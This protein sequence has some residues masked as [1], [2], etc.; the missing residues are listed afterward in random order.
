MQKLQNA[1]IIAYVYLHRNE[2]LQT[3]SITANSPRK[4]DTETSDSICPVM[5]VCR[6]A[7]CSQST[8]DIINLRF[9]R[10]VVSGSRRV[11]EDRIGMLCTFKAKSN[12]TKPPIFTFRHFLI[13]PLSSNFALRVILHCKNTPGS[14]SPR[15]LDSSVNGQSVCSG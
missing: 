1:M 13:S 11:I 10:R 5:L 12:F 9:A 8:H 14:T 15:K 6:F 3:K 2:K 4:M 7:F